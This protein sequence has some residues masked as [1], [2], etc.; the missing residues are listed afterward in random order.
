MKKI[1]KIF[2]TIAI[3]LLSSLA[4]TVDAKVNVT[5]GGGGT[6][7]AS[8][9]SE[10]AWVYSSD[11]LG[12][13]LSLY[14]YDEKN[15][16]FKT[17]ID[18]V[19]QP[20]NYPAK[21][22]TTKD[23]FGRYSYTKLNK[24]IDFAYY[25]VGAKDIN[26]YGFSTINEDSDSWSTK[27]A[28]EVQNYF[29]ETESETISGIKKM[30]GVTVPVNEL[31]QYY[32]VAEPT[33]FFYSRVGQFYTYATGY[34]YMVV[35]NDIDKYTGNY[36]WN[37]WESQGRHTFLGYMFNGMYNKTDSSIETEIKKEWGFTDGRYD[38]Y[39]FLSRSNNKSLVKTTSSLISE[40]SKIRDNNAY[41]KSNYPYGVMVFWIGK[42][43]TIIGGCEN[44]CT[45]KNGN[46]L[47][48]DA[49]LKCA[50][51]YCS[52][53]DNVKNKEDKADCIT[54][55]CK[56]TF[57][58]LT[59]DNT[60]SKN[61]N[62]TVCTAS[63]NSN[64]KTCEI[65]NTQNYSYKVECQNFSTV[66]FPETLPSTFV[67]G[68][69]FEYRVRLYGNKTCTVKLDEALWKYNYAS[70]YTDTERQT[71][72]NA[73]NSYNSLNFSDY[74]FD[75]STANINVNIDK[76]K[77]GKKSTDKVQLK[78]EE[79]YEHGDKKVTTTY[80]NQNIVS[81]HKNSNVTK[82]VKLYTTESSNGT[83][84]ELPGVCISEKDNETPKE[85]SVCEKGLG[86]YN[87][88]YTNIYADEGN[89]NIETTVTYNPAGLD[90]VVNKCDYTIT[91]EPLSC[92]IDVQTASN[93]K[94]ETLK[95]NEDINFILTVIT[96]D[97]TRSIRKNI[98]TT[99]LTMDD[100]FNNKNVYTILKNTITTNKDITVYGTVTDG[101]HIAICEKRVNIN[102]QQCKWTVTENNNEVTVSLKQIKNTNAKYYIRTSTSNTWM[103]TRTRT[104]NKTNKLEIE[105][106]IVSGSDTYT[107]YYSA[108][109]S[110]QTCTELYEPAQYDKIRNYCDTSWQNDTANYSSAN[111]CF[112]GCTGTNK[113]KILHACTE[114]EK[115]RNY[116]KTNF[117]DDGYE[118]VGSCINDCSCGGGLD[119]YYRTISVDDPFPKRDAHYNWLGYEEYITND[120]DDLTSSYTDSPEYEIVLDKNRIDA[121]KSDTKRYN[122]KTGNDAYGDYIRYDKEDEET[123][124]FNE[125]YKSKFIHFD[126]T[127][128]GGF[129]SYFT[130]I[131]GVK[132]S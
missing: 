16:V 68:Q 49:L 73:L 108:N 115:I 22:N 93:Q 100:Q 15:L 77:D 116:C 74:Y 51:N 6:P 107:C 10:C 111:D 79:R 61:G 80:T 48:G 44:V 99:P 82:L 125:P 120:K 62:D 27:F 55:S 121:I 7:P 75:S 24:T 52:S 85:G 83:Y 71:Y 41:A 105:G 42:N 54:N 23:K 18:L 35:L 90:N 102:P 95:N 97:R 67:A 60:T 114:V 110:G 11:G 53:L 96:Q 132:T 5:P 72:I 40:K 36:S 8:G 46:K 20:S 50:E 37:L 3:A 109:L 98:G 78:A 43:S 64:K 9:C 32:I 113:C 1:N 94:G 38:F 89:N 56:Y 131:E 129:K 21:A 65:K 4:L 84:Y 119:Y 130:Y 45:D 25:T 123:S 101:E 30:F 112:T 19:N 63:T 12:V 87:K 2:F 92:Y 76:S 66:E 26:N 118:N 86:P 117:A 33:A 47:T 126:D 58:R 104:F 103:E 28:K 127:E 29:G 39:N 57:T 81:Y 17:S 69:G 34:E 106:K 124:D 59:C 31:S 122:S 13:R 88:Y 91:D 14:K 70:S 128:N